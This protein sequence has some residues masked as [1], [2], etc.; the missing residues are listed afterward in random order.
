MT[1]IQQPDEFCFS[2]ALK[3]IIIQSEED[4]DVSFSIQGQDSFLLETYTPDSDE[5]IYIRDLV[6]LFLPYISK[7][8]LRETFVINITGKESETTET[9][10]TTVLYGLAEINLDAEDF[11]NSN[12]L[13][14][15]P[16]EKITYP[17]QKE[18]LSMIV[19]ESTVVTIKAKR[20]SGATETKTLN[21][22]TLNQVI[23]IDVSAGVFNDP[24]TIDFIV[25]LADERKFTYFIRRPSAP[26]APQF[27]FLNAFGVK[28][29]FIPAGV[30]FRENKYEN[31]F[32]QFSGRYKKYNIELVKEYTANTGVM[33]EKTAD[34]IE[35][36]F[37]SKDV[38]LLTS[39]GIE[40]EIAIS[41][42]TVK[43]STARDALPAYD[44]K[45]RLSKFNQHQYI[46]GNLS[47]IFDDTF[48]YSFN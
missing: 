1:I 4:L 39:S 9:V 34:W 18:F 8:T 5:K 15:L 47:R 23:T 7:T 2:S 21:V 37:M 19:L 42:A 3:D 27:L 46:I 33:S 48:D 10:T 40:S 22:T 25:V 31:Q 32:G 28:E 14:L 6:K 45:Y 36:M 13:T 44:I 24:E 12:F 17:E 38:F 26:D 41:D 30:V 11:L 43:R 20:Q 16:R 29:T 35:D